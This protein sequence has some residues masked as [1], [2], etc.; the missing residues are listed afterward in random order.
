MIDLFL[1]R[2]D[3]VILLGV[4]LSAATDDKVGSIVSHLL[5]VRLQR[6]V[7]GLVPLGLV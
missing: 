6:K 2:L 7:T 3:L 4:S 5:V 1:I